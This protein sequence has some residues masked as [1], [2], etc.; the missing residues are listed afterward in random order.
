[1][2]ATATPAV[3]AAAAIISFFIFVF[4]FLGPQALR[5]VARNYPRTQFLVS[6]LGTAPRC[7]DVLQTPQTTVLV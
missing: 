4:L 3:K 7:Q 5:I 1:M 2:S 6:P